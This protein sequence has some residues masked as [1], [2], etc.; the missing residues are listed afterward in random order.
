MG[1]TTKHHGARLFSGIMYR[2]R[3]ILE[4]TV[5]ALE[6]AFGK[7]SMRSPEFDFDFTDY[8]TDEMGAGLKKIFI[9]FEKPVDPGT[10][11]EI[12]TF[13]NELE[14]KLG[15]REVGGVARRKVNIDPGYVGL[16]KV[17]LASTKNRS[18]RIYLGDGI[19]AE[20][21]LNYKGGKW[22]PLPWT[23]PDF[24]TQL[25]QDFLTR[26]RASL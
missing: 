9:G 5:T 19:Y 11:A 26:L 2:E 23:Y 1:A 15:I 8:Y 25:A 13:T 21:T 20:V 12:K 10:L 3:E 22:E 4:Q 24:K 6:S 14:V 17:V 16:S 7:V 18:Q